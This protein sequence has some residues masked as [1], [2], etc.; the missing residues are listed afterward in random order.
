MQ[1]NRR[2]PLPDGPGTRRPTRAPRSSREVKILSVAGRLGRVR[3]IG[4]SVGMSLVF[5]A[6]HRPGRGPGRQRPASGCSVARSSL[7]P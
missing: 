1:Q 5:Y 4:Y 6:V 7:P 3:Y 2:Q